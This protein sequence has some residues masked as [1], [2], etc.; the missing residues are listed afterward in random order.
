MSE[1][2]NTAQSL[3]AD[4]ERL[5]TAIP[6]LET[7]INQIDNLTTKGVLKQQSTL[8]PALVLAIDT[9]LERSESLDDT[10][11]WLRAQ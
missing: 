5:R 11:E 4:A 7:A 3:E 10:A 2:I 8:K 1:R 6:I 9:M